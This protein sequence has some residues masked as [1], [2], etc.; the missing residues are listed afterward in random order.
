MKIVKINE[1]IQEY[2]L[3]NGL[4]VYLHHN[5]S[6]K[7]YYANYTVNFG[8]NDTYY[9][10]GRTTHKDPTGIAHYLEHLMFNKKDGDYFD[11][12][13]KLGASANAYTNYKQT[14][15]LFSSSN[16][17]EQNLKILLNMVQSI[18]I[19]KPIVQKELG[20]ITEELNM[21]NLKPEFLNFQYLMENICTNNY[22][23]D[24][25]GDVESIKEINLTMLRR[26]YQYFYNPSNCI[27]FISGNLPEDLIQTI[28]KLQKIRKQKPIKRIIK[29]DNKFKKDSSKQY[30]LSN[31]KTPISSLAL[32]TQCVEDKN[33]ILRLLA[34]D[35]FTDYLSSPVNSIY[36]KYY[37]ED[38]LDSTFSTSYIL[39]ED[40]SLILLSHYKDDKDI[41]LKYLEECISNISESDIN[42]LINKKV[43]EDIK[44]FNNPKQIAEDNL[45]LLLLNID[46]NQYYNTL[47]NIKPKQIIKEIK[48]ML[49]K[50]QIHT[51]VMN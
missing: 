18:D 46:I 32:K 37:K 41:L 27:L 31:A 39:E 38:I 10:I 12:F 49:K 48:T 20:I 6:F 43:G 51:Q 25:G 42:N 33:M 2:N 14:S 21:Y 23:Y 16:N 34:F 47:F 29:P 8:S 3:D 7:Q 22:Q 1:D 50:K 44:V 4:K 36:N 13:S 35:I 11:D 40:I 30:S 26:I 5:P 24:I 45:E 9:K 15:Y 28:N 17:L 19:T